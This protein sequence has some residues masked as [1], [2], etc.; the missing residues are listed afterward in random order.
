MILSA[1][2]SFLG[3]SGFR[4]IWGEISSYL[5]KTQDHAHEVELLRLQSALE[6][7][8]AERSIA[9]IR[10]QSELNV[11]QVEVQSAADDA[12]GAAEAFTA[13]MENATKPTGIKLVDIWNGVIRPAYASFFLALIVLKVYSQHWKMDEWDMALAG[14]VAGFFFADRSLTKKAK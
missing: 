8:R 14:M 10:L 2:L 11:Q 7:A 12:K 4:M 5:T 13:A 9:N 3:G 1:L 6:D